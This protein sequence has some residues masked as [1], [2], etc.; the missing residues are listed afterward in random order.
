[1]ANYLVAALYKFVA[2]PDCAELKA[3]LL[4]FCEAQDIT[5]TIL[6]APEGINGTIAGA[7][8][9]VQAVLAYLRQDPRLADLAHKESSAEK[10]P[11]YRVKVRLKPEI[12][13]MGV[14]ELNPAEQ[15]GTYV[16]PQAWN[17]LLNDPDVVVIDARNDYEVAIGTFPGAINPNTKSF[18]EL[19]AW[20]DQQEALQTK[21]KVAMFCTG[22]IRCEKSTAYL[23]SQGFGEVY[24]LQ[25]GILKY[26]ETVPQTESLWQGECFVFD[27]RVAVV[28]GL[29]T[30]TYELCR[31]CRQP[32][33][34]ADKA[35]KQYEPGVSCPHCY[36]QKSEEKKQ[37]LAE[38]QKQVTLANQRQQRHVGA[39]LQSQEKRSSEHRPATP[40]PILYSF[41]RC[42]F[43]MRARMALAVSDRVCELREVVLRDKPQALLD[44]SAKGTVPVLVEANGRVIDQ[45][46]EIMLWA[47]QHHD[48][49]QW[50]LPEQGTFAE[51][52]QLIGTCDGEFKHHLDRYKY[53]TRYENT[54]ALTH[55]TEAARFLETLNQQLSQTLYLFG[56]R[57]SLADR[58]I[59]PFV[60]QFSLADP[61]WFQAQPWPNLY[62]WLAAWVESELYATIMPKYPQWQS[63]DAIVRFPCLLES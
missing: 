35:S 24:H 61:E 28:H 9:Q 37:R 52:M 23:R 2:L 50:L 53:A 47:L 44:A 62:T 51:M 42:P 11:F 34:P 22:G 10:Q 43:A 26:L 19:P 30:G 7:P 56:K 16:E 59:V 58:A 57:P 13:T 49:E 27:E 29:D 48:P 17:E 63:G 18:S 38:R 39:R 36:G 20:L 6:L 14:P 40:L 5:G 32:I 8:A 4:A 55:R 45:S 46:L 54:D 41:R 15:A 33:S 1:M 12:V 60:R 21:P 25:G 3:P 31:A